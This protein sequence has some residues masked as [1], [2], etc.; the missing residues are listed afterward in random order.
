LNAWAIN[1][2]YFVAKAGEFTSLGKLFLTMEADDE[3]KRKTD[4]FWA[5]RMTLRGLGILDMMA[6]LAV[7]APRET[8]ASLHKLFGLGTLPDAPIVGY[9]ARSASFLYALH[10]ALILFVSMDVP[11]YLPLIKFMA[12]AAVFHGLAMFAIDVGVGMPVWWRCAEG[13]GFSVT[14][15]IVLLSLPGRR[16]QVSST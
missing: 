1:P 9:L 5:A 4:D 3:E 11:R 13:L 6:I 14:G 2:T 7:I 10:G 8:I 15:V 16:R 12:W